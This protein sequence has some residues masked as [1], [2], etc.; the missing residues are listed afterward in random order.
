MKRYKVSF[1]IL[2]LILLVAVAGVQAGGKGA[3]PAGKAELARVRAATA[4]FHRTEAAMAAGWDI[5][6][7]HCVENPGVGGMGYHYINGTLIDLVI[8]PTQPEVLV[9]APGPNDGLRLAAVEYMI[10]AEPWDAANDQPPTALGQ[11]MHLNPM[12]G[13]YVLHAW[14][15]RHNPAG[16][17]EDWNPK[18]SC[19]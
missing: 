19:P 16:M 5:A 10:P 6:D 17:F 9:Y 8:E 14:I 4:G 12:L 11:T 18:V 2:S 1:L 3:P 7:P 15:W 13:A